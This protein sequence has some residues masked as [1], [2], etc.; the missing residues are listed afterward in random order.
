MLLPSLELVSV[1][2]PSLV[3]GICLELCPHDLRR[4]PPTVQSIS[5]RESCIRNLVLEA[6]ASVALPSQ[7]RDEPR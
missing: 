3:S 1:D 5:Y 4:R 7:P 2:V 6:L